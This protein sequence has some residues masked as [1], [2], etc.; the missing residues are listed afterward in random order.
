MKIELTNRINPL[1]GNYTNYYSEGH[2]HLEKSWNTSINDQFAKGRV[3]D[4]VYRWDSN[5][6]IPFEDMLADFVNNGLMDAEVFYTSA[7]VRKEEDAASIQAYIES[8][9]N[10]KPSEEEL[11]E[12]R[13]AFGPGERVVNVFT[14]RVTQL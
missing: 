14:G 8:Q 9:K 7:K 4:G 5:D 13:A 10:V 2:P 11:F 3:V 6:R 1:T 12:M